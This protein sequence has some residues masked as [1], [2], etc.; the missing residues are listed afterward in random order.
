MSSIDAQETTKIVLSQ[1]DLRA[2]RDPSTTPR[3]V[4]YAVT[5]SQGRI[6]YPRFEREILAAVQPPR[7]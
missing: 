3:Q 6:G 2:L 7:T 5:D 1:A 4:D